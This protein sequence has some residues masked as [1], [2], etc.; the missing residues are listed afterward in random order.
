MRGQGLRR[1][2]INQHGEVRLALSTVEDTGVDER[3]SEVRSEIGIYF[4]ACEME[5]VK[6]KR[7]SEGWVTISTSHISVDGDLNNDDVDLHRDKTTH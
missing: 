5:R 4:F 6:R 7:G 3:M 2:R 1:A